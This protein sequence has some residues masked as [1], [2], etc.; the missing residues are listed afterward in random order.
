MKKLISLSTMLLITILLTS[1]FSLNTFA[2]PIKV[3]DDYDVLTDQEEALLDARANELSEELGIDIV[4]LTVYSLGGYTPI[5]FG[6]AF[7]SEYGYAD[8]S[9]V[10]LLSFEERDYAI[11]T[12]GIAFDIFTEYASNNA[13]DHFISYISAENY[14]HGFN[15]FL[16]QAEAKINHYYDTGYAYGSEP[17]S[18]VTYILIAFVIAVV[19]A[20]ITV[21][22]LKSQLNTAVPKGSAGDY[23]SNFRLD[24]SRDIFLY[25]TVTKTKIEKSSGG[26]GGGGS[27]STGGGTSGKF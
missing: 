22:I 1:F 18:I 25:S 21:F 14:Y 23:L 5:S 9:V 6:E 19:I 17:I 4:I 11:A 12:Q 13:V 8:D 10:F 20:L 2:S 24:Q 27:R 26:G 16:T 15:E 7:L 3:F